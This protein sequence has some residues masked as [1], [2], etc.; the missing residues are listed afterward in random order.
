VQGHQAHRK[1]VRDYF[2]LLYNSGMGGAII[3]MTGRRALG[4]FPI[5]TGSVALLKLD[6]VL[7]I[8]FKE[9]SLSE[10]LRWTIEYALEY[11]LDGYVADP[12]SIA[13][14][15]V[16]KTARAFWR[17][18]LRWSTGTTLETLETIAGV[19]A[20]RR[21]GLS[22]K[23][24]YLLQGGFYSQGLYVYIATLLP[25]LA[26]LLGHRME[27]WPLGLYLW[28]TGITTIILAGSQLER[29]SLGEGIRVVVALLPYIYYTSLI[30]AIGFIKALIFRRAEWVTTPKR[31]SHEEEYTW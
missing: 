20:S 24:G 22:H 27:P 25:P 21:L 16:P 5:F 26:A 7:E 14:G 28:L 12:H 1:G 6:R 10:D 19:L 13:V 3:F 4:M 9:G 23:I 15:S 2:G 18:Q 30:H 29:R 31:G 17:Q 11:G 8:P